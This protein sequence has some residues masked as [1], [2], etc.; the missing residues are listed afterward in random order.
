MANLTAVLKTL[1]QSRVEAMQHK[2][3]AVDSFNKLQTQYGRWEKA[4]SRRQGL[5]MPV[6]CINLPDPP[7]L[8]AGMTNPLDCSLP[9]VY[10]AVRNAIGSQKDSRDN[11]SKVVSMRTKLMDT[12]A[13]L[14]KHK[15]TAAGLQA[16]N[17]ALQVENGAV[18]ERVRALEASIASQ[19]ALDFR[20]S[21]CQRVYQEGAVQ[22]SVGLY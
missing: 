22:R 4:V 8:P 11:F 21:V 18:M 17:L 1:T 19:P 3:Q 13:E 9:N 6:L 5:L 2:V 12:Q 7:I 14:R 16:R 20:L 15:A 10:R